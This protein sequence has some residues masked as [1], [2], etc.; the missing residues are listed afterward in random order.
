[1]ALSV[2][3]VIPTFNAGPD[4]ARLLSA[5]KQQTLRPLDVVVVDSGS[6][7]QTL[8]AAAEFGAT[9]VH[10]KERFDHGLARDAGIA[11]A[12]GDIVVLTVQDAVPASNDWLATLTRHFVDASVAGVFSRQIPPPD[13]PLELQIKADLDAA[14]GAPDFVRIADHPNYATYSPAEK[15]ELYRFDDVNSALRKIVWEKLPFGPCKYAEDLQWARKAL[16]AG[17]TL[18][19]EPHAP[20]VHAHR[21]S[22]SYEFRRG[23]LD[24]WM[25]DELFGYR[26]SFFKKLNRVSAMMKGSGGKKASRSGAFKTYSAHALARGCY[27]FYR[28]FLKPFGLGRG[29][30]ARWSGGI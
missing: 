4:L 14:A 8:A 11:A 29:T 13:G 2:S 28:C 20:V 27:G 22:F 12:R 25:L 17:L 16:E 3:V 30:L 15:L 5:L 23:L 21:R 18:V 9:I 7:D 1:M 6:K 24:A 19:R 10:Y 26:Y